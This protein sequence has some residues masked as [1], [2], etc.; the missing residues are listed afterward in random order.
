MLFVHNY[1]YTLRISIIS[2][3][4][5]N[6]FVDSFW[7]RLKQKVHT[8]NWQDRKRFGIFG[9]KKRRGRK[10]SRWKAQPNCLSLNLGL[11]LPETNRI[12]QTRTVPVLVRKKK[13][14]QVSQ[15][16]FLAWFRKVNLKGF[17][18]EN[19]ISISQKMQLETVYV[20]SYSTFP[21]MAQVT[22]GLFQACPLRQL[23]PAV[24]PSQI[25]V[26]HAVGSLS[27]WEAIK[28][29]WSTA[30]VQPI[31]PSIPIKD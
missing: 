23:A 1:F 12:K 26:G 30:T 18:K 19:A 7:G 16:L 5:L 25:P 4:C 15:S 31:L 9:Q 11:S 27:S 2:I 14:G 22:L 17:S 28:V 21:K 20:V 13:A 8:I 6:H 3:A 29:L 24:F 10:N